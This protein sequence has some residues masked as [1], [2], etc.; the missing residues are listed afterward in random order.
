MRNAYTILEGK[1]EEEIPLEVLN[2]IHAAQ[3]TASWR[4]LV[5]II[6]DLRAP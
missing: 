5:N 2:W 4:D 1:S 6:M 3:S